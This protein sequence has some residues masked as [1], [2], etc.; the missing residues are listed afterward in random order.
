MRLAKQI[1]MVLLIVLF[2]FFAWGQIFFV[3]SFSDEGVLEKL[4]YEMTVLEGTKDKPQVIRLEGTLPEVLTS[5]H[6]RLIFRGREL[7]VRIGNELRGEY[8]T[9]ADRVVGKRS[10]EL[11]LDV[12]LEAADAGKTFSADINLV[13]GIVHPVYVGG[14][15]ALW[16][17]LFESLGAEIVIGM[18]ALLF[19]VICIV[20]AAILSII[21]RSYISLLDLAVGVVLGAVWIIVNS[22][23]RQL[24]FPND[25]LASDMPFM[26]ILFLPFPFLFYTNELQK[27]R[28]EKY[29]RG[30]IGLNFLDVIAGGIFYNLNSYGLEDYFIVEASCCLLTIVLIAATVI[31]DVRKGKVKEYRYAAYGMLCTVICA[32]IQ[33]VLYFFRTGLFSG[34]VIAIALVILLLF[35]TINAVLDVV[36]LERETNRAV[37]SNK[38]KDVFLANMS[39]EIRTPINAILGM[40]EMILMETREESVKNYAK[41][42]RNAGRNLLAIINDILDFSKIESGKMEIIPVEYETQSLIHDILVLI[43]EKVSEKNLSLELD[44]SPELPTMLRG[45]VAR[46]R[47]V[48]TNLL[49]NAVKYTEKGTIRWSIRGEYDDEKE[50]IILHCSVVDSGIGM[51]K[52][53]LET[54]F[55]RFSRMDE[56][57]NY[58]VQGTGL[59][60][61]ITKHLLD[62][63]GSKLEVESVYGEGS[64]FFFSLRQEVIKRKPIGELEKW[65]EHYDVPYEKT[66]MKYWGQGSVLVVDD[67]AMNR[68]VF[69]SLLSHSGLQVEEAQSGEECLA[70]TEQKDYDIVFLDHMMPELDGVQTLRKIRER[71]GEKGKIIVVVLTANAISG[72]R[73]QYFNEGFNDYIAKPILPEKLDSVLDKWLPYEA[74]DVFPDEELPEMS[75]NDAKD[76][77]ILSEIVSELEDIPEIDLLY[78][79]RFYSDDW[80]LWETIRDF[81]ELLE[82]E[83]QTLQNTYKT[84]REAIKRVGES[85]AG[86]KIQDAS[87]KSEIKAVRI[88]VHAMKSSAKAIGALTLGGFAQY[89]EDCARR[90]EVSALFALVPLF[91]REWESYRDKLSFVDWYSYVG[92]ESELEP[93]DELIF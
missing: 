83:S 62:L 67:Q 76:E 88:Q 58:N 7:T 66:P 73:E 87:A 75:E 68:R 1:F 78:A 79:R 64:C 31:L 60:L 21:R 2:L 92:R 18:F 40:D 11:Y 74:Q 59:G 16:K 93:G 53:D 82:E 20:G 61:A 33:I 42:V 9:A 34:V 56:R 81:Y 3:P 51:K 37:S 89:L 80:E 50:E 32:A 91:I 55:E 49:S 39:H 14:R 30:L 86:E 28:Y 71:P 17:M 22:V 19:G 47:Q 84:M 24:V 12:P 8:A 29:F 23:F 70:L 10:P 35:S 57:R 85:V 44:M 90:E 5:E 38:A 69:C 15:L 13:A 27:A 63:M 46:L 65:I 6:E 45:D 72:A 36:R 54:L 4:D 77:S 48:F 25:S 43:Q 52:E 41:D 26:V